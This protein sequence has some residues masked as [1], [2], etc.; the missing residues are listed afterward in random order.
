MTAKPKNIINAAFLVCLLFGVGH[1]QTIKGR[2]V[3]ITDC[4]TLT[5]LDGQNQQQKIRLNGIDAPESSQDFGQ[6]SKRN[7]SSLVFDRDVV[8]EWRKKDRYGRIVG[9]V[10]VSATNANLEQL[11]AGL[12]WYYRQYAGDVAPE[13]RP[14]YD[15]A[16]ADARAGKRGLWARPNPQPPW[17]YR[18]PD[19]SSPTPTSQPSGKIIGNRNSS[20]YHLPNC[21]DYN[22]VSERNRIYFGTET[23][24]IKDGFR[25]ARN[26]P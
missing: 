11:K 6:V 5:V 13:L 15:R 12:A 20:I 24:A 25:K 23:D 19:Q 14:I 16:E 1:S 4:D 21:P 22:K 2:V 8:V 18:H 26:C 9:T 3:A 17:E 7:L 10:K